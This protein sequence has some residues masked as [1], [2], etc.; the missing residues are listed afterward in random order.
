VLSTFYH[1][2]SCI[3]DKDR[4]I[5][6]QTKPEKKS[7]HYDVRFVSG[8]RVLTKQTTETHIVMYTL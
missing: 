3:A 1:T 8:L 2:M 5:R 4:R 7:T 6:K